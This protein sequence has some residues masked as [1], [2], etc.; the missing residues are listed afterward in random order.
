M[1]IVLSSWL[2][3]NNFIFFYLL[4]LLFFIHVIKIKP[5]YLVNQEYNPS[6]WIFSF[7]KKYTYNIQIFYRINNTDP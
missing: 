3:L 6:Y 7:F 5:I 4:S 1:Y 2:K